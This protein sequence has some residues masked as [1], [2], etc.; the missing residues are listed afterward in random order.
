MW[1]QAE[2]RKAPRVNFPCRIILSPELSQEALSLHT[3]NISLGGLRVI[4]DKKL[5]VN[6]VVSLEL[7]AE[8]SPIACKGRIAWVQQMH[9]TA[10]D[11]ALLFDVGVEFTDMTEQ[12][13]KRLR[14]FLDRISKRQ[15]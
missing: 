11:K 14:V 13:Q 10:S 15:L 12:N 2:R 4:S 5:S 3:E 1:D 6:M 9:P 7:F 8:L